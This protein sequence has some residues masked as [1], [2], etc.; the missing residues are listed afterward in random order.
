VKPP[1]AAQRVE[2][3]DAEVDITHVQR[4]MPDYTWP[5]RMPLDALRRLVERESRQAIQEA[6]NSHLRTS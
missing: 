1:C 5:W 6:N 3:L 4:V 2:W